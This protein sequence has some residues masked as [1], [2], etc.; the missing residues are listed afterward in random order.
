MSSL[1]GTGHLTI[2]VLFKKIKPGSFQDYFILGAIWALT[3]IIFDYFF[4]VR[5]F[6]L[7]DGYYKL[8]VYL[9]Y[10]ITFILPLLFGWKKFH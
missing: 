9:Y 6:K 1:R 7:A 4:L 2:W 5:L 10:L 3:A 8:D